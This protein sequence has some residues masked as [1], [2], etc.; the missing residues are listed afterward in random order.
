LVA[1]LVSISPSISPTTVQQDPE[2]VL[3][4]ANDI[5][6][7]SLHPSPTPIKQDPETVLILVEDTEFLQQKPNTQTAASVAGTSSQIPKDIHEGGILER[8]LVINGYYKWL[9]QDINPQ[10]RPHKQKAESRHLFEHFRALHLAGYLFTPH[11]L[12]LYEY[13]IWNQTHWRTRNRLIRL[14]STQK[15]KFRIQE[16]IDTVLQRVSNPEISTE[17]L[18]REV[19]P[20][21]TPHFPKYFPKYPL[22]Q[23]DTVDYKTIFGNAKSVFLI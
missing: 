19:I 13:L 6:S 12:Q 5:E 4:S 1:A 16:A 21:E 23:D 20:N 11:Q 7:P 2:S 9:R 8:F 22:S 17:E 18:Y 14:V 3:F 10:D 15:D